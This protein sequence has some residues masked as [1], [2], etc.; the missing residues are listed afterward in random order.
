MRRK[1]EVAGCIL[2]A[3]HTPE[4]RRGGVHSGATRCEVLAT[5]SALCGSAPQRNN[6]L[7]EEKKI[8]NNDTSEITVS[9]LKQ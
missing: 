2:Q 9:N 4:E 6:E 1:E 5:D 8:N 3:V 7:C